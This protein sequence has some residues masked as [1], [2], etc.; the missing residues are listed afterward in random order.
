MWF[1]QMAGELRKA[2]STSDR[3]PPLSVDVCDRDLH[4]RLISFVCSTM[5]STP[6]IFVK[7]SNKVFLLAPFGPCYAEHAFV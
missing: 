4:D 5:V 6:T 3:L 1:T 7:S 2:G